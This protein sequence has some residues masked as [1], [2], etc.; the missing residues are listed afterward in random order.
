MQFPVSHFCCCSVKTVP[1]TNETL[2]TFTFPLLSTFDYCAHSVFFLP[3]EH[4]SCF[5]TLS[6]FLLPPRTPLVSWDVSCCTG[7]THT[8]SLTRTRTH[9]CIQYMHWHIHSFT[10]SG[11]LQHVASHRNWQLCHCGCETTEDVCASHT[12]WRCRDLC[13]VEPCARCP[14]LRFLLRR[15]IIMWQPHQSCRTIKNNSSLWLYTVW[16]AR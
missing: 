3:V 9:S 10:L 8:H 5:H 11:T 4:L 12:S 16:T 7:S 6:H 15:V 1:Q 2:F 14:A 13:L